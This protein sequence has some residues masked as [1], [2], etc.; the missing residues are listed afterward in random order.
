MYVKIALCFKSTTRR[1]GWEL[2][3]LPIF[4]LELDKRFGICLSVGWLIIEMT[5]FFIPERGFNELRKNADNRTEN[6]RD[7]QTPREET[8][9]GE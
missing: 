7:V 5:C 8:G 1:N 9:A 2:K 3:V 6:R 4:T